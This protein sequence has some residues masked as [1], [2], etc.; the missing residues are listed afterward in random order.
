[1][2]KRVILLVVIFVLLVVALLHLDLV[3]SDPGLPIEDV[4]LVLAVMAYFSWHLLRGKLHGWRIA[5]PSVLMLVLAAYVWTWARG[6]YRGAG[7]LSIEGVLLAFPGLYFPKD[8]LR[9]TYTI[10]AETDRPHTE[11]EREILSGL[12]SRGV[13]VSALRIHFLPPASPNHPSQ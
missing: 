2:L 12:R 10:L 4:P 5:V 6:Q 11:V 13:R 3:H 8:S 1:M 7:S 9:Y